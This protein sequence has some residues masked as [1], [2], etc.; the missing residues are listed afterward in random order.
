[1]LHE[2]DMEFLVIGGI[3]LTFGTAVLVWGLVRCVKTWYGAYQRLKNR[4][5]ILA[6]VYF[7]AGCVFAGL[8]VAGVLILLI[9]QVILKNA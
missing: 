8:S 5:R 3:F 4:Q 2:V 7:M 6:F 1:M 9:A